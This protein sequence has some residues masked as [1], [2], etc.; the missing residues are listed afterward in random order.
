MIWEGKS[1]RKRGNRHEYS[2]KDRNMR[3]V[4][5]YLLWAYKLGLTKSSFAG[6]TTVISFLFCPKLS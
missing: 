6:S 4:C 5:N 3:G 1:I 2:G